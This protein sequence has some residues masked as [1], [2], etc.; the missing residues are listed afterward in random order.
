MGLDTSK[1]PSISFIVVI[2]TFIGLI[3]GVPVFAYSTFVTIRERD[4]IRGMYDERLKSIE[5]SQDV[6][7]NTQSLMS[8]KLDALILMQQERRK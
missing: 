2:A 6:I 7:T 8:G 5:H 4:L 1:N 3:V